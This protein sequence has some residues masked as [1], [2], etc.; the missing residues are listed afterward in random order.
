MGSVDTLDATRQFSMGTANCVAELSIQCCV[1]F[2]KQK[3]ERLPDALTRFLVR[4]LHNSV[5]IRWRTRGPA[6]W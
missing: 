3:V 2:P 4:A 5:D 6:R 1:L